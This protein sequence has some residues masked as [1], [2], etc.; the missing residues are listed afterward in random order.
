ME[1]SNGNWFLVFG[2]LLSI[3][4]TFFI[5]TYSMLEIDGNKWFNK[6][7]PALEDYNK[8]IDLDEDVL[9]STKSLGYVYATLTN[10]FSSIDDVI[11][12]N[13]ILTQENIILSIEINSFDKKKLL[14]MI[15]SVIRSLQNKIDIV[16]H[17][18]SQDTIKSMKIGLEIANNIREYGYKGQLNVLNQ[19]EKLDIEQYNN[20][21]IDLVI[22]KE[23]NNEKNII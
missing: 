21:T 9:Y 13:N 10:K 6:L 20:T 2:D 19:V 23:K 15:Q 11:I 8:D 5:L 18:N 3:L 4:L 16:V 1:E 7:I 14:D 12:K 17:S 22:Y